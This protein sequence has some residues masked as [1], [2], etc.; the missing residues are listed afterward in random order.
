M[1]NLYL[2]YEFEKFE[3]GKS[4]EYAKLLAVAVNLPKFEDK[5]KE[6][7]KKET[8]EFIDNGQYL[9]KINVYRCQGNFNFKRAEL[10]PFN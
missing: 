1:L 2:V 5:Y 3:N 6:R 10:I 7:A 8:F 9:H 4:V